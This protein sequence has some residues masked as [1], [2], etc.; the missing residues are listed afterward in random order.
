MPKHSPVWGGTWASGCTG[1]EMLRR[2]LDAVGISYAVDG[3]DGPQYAAD[4]HSLRHT[5]LTMLGRNGVDL[6]TAQELAGHSTPLLTARYSHRRLYD[7]VGAVDRLPTLVPI[8]PEPD[9]GMTETSPR[10]TGT[11]HV[12]DKLGVPPGVPNGYA[13]R[14]QTAASDN[15][16]VIGE[17]CNR[18]P[19]PV[20]MQGA[21]AIQHRPASVRSELPGKDSNLDKESQNLFRHC[22]CVSMHVVERLENQR[23]RGST[24][25]PYPLVSTALATDWLHWL[26]EHPAGWTLCN[27]LLGTPSPR[28]PNPRP[29]LA[30]RTLANLTI[31]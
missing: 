3:P 18:L 7:L 5:Y 9:E 14:H 21:G 15:L 10:L 29:F 12:A 20:E 11:E 30:P 28:R 16:Q 24:F 17:G 27:D 13:G 31:F 26:H 19:Q 4:F 25:S 6:R 2:D 22:P 8:T 1:A 23:F